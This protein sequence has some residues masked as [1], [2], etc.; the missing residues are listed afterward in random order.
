MQISAASVDEAISTST[1]RVKAIVVVHL[2]GFAADMNALAAVAADH[3]VPIIEDAAQAF[4]RAHQAR[5]GG[6]FW[7]RWHCFKFFPQQGARAD[8]YG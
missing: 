7:R 5:S 3:D 2:F 6:N 8:V 4:R 1:L